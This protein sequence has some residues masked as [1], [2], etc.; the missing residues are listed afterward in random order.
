MS[1]ESPLYIPGEAKASATFRLL[2]RINETHGLSLETYHDLYQW[3]TAHLDLFWGIVWDETKI[4]GTKGAHIVD[5]AA[6]PPSN[7]VWY[8]IIPHGPIAL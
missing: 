3:S 6:L 7:P 4:I 5:N 2:R 1:D 8:V